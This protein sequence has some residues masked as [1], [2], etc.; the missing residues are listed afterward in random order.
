MALCKENAG[1]DIML[2]SHTN[3]TPS[4]KE[5]GF[6]LAIEVDDAV[7]IEQVELKLAD[8]LTWMEGVGRCE[9]THMGVLENE[10]E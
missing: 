10:G 8:A 5:H 7:S 1:V 3:R 9:V 2:Q 6:I 4:V